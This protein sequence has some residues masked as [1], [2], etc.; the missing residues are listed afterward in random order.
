MSNIVYNQAK[1]RLATG[2]LDLD[3]D[4]IKVIPLGVAPNGGAAENPDTDTV[5]AVLADATELSCT[6]YTGGVGSTDRK[7]LTV[8]ATLDDTNNRSNVSHGGATWSALSAGTHSSIAGYLIYEHVSGA[9]DSQNIP[10]MYVNASP[11][12]SL[13]LNGSDVSLPSGDFVRLA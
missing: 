3:S 12:S 11:F 6:G 5:T 1:N 7:T 2:A 9:D 10:I 8:T 13:A 4:T